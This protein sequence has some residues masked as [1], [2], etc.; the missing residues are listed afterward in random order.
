[1]QQSNALLLVDDEEDIT[2]GITAILERKGYVVHSFNDGKKA[3]EHLPLCSNCC[4]LISDIR[5]PGM[6][7]F[8]L[9]QKL[10]MMRPEIKIILMSAYQLTLQ[11]IAT[12][13]PSTHIDYF[14]EKPV[15][16]PRFVEAIAA[17]DKEKELM[18]NR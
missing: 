7:G 3:V 13:I 5:M 15:D 2:T 6:N 12:I 10:K 8:E 9:A 18:Q 4:T 14:F 11:E 17:I 16:L 1:M